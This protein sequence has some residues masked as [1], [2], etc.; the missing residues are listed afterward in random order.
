MTRHCEVKRGRNVISQQWYNVRKLDVA[1]AQQTQFGV[2]WNLNFF[3]QC[4]V[5]QSPMTLP[6]VE[7]HN[8]RTRELNYLELVYL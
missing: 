2:G 5:D 1:V 3:V 8:S 6:I 7:T 4:P